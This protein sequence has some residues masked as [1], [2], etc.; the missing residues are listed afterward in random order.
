M[1]TYSIIV[2]NTK[3]EI[4][5]RNIFPNVLHKIYYNNL[6]PVIFLIALSITFAELFT[7]S[8]L[9]YNLFN[10]VSL[11]LLI[12]LYGGGVVAIREFTVHY[13][14]EWPA[15]LLLGSAYGI[16]EEGFATKTFFDPGKA[17]F[18]GIFGRA[19]G[20]N[21]VWVVLII[22]FHAI[23]TITL[24]VLLLRVAFP[25]TNGKPIV[26]SWG[27]YAGLTSF[28]A[29]AILLF[30]F[31]DKTYFP[32]SG[33]IISFALLSIV[34]VLIA[35]SFPSGFFNKWAYKRS[36]NTRKIA[37][38]GAMAVWMAVFINGIAPL[39]IPIPFLIIL[40]DVIL[41]ISTLWIVLDS[42]MI[43]NNH[44]TIIALSS[45]LLSFWIA[46]SAIIGAIYDYGVEIATVLVIAILYY[47][48]IKANRLSPESKNPSI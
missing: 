27:K 22:A 41:G 38:A 40:M 33:L 45:G 2:F 24:P 17:G 9:F 5:K 47:L 28:T 46:Y 26:P 31:G 13:K 25:Y 16:V 34:F 3:T 36:V 20:V 4:N 35:V 1:K 12:G 37:I 32:S 29:T 14:W 30:F 19:Y 10:P 7:G 43:S 44:R 11:L 21:W 18:L 6:S 23:Y 42:G 39:F 48:W 8:T 15:L